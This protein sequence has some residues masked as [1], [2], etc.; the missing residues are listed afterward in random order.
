MRPLILILLFALL[1]ISQINT[2]VD[3]DLWLHIK[4]GEYIVKNLSIPKIDIFSYTLENQALIHYDW[5]SGV[6]YY[7]IFICFGWACINILKASVIALCFFILFLIA[8]KE[9]KIIYFIFFAV[10][11]ILA[12]DYRS[13][14]RPEI[15]SYLLLCVFLYILEKDRHVYLLPLLQV[16]WVNLHGYFILGPVLIV[17]YF[18]NEIFYGNIIKSKRLFIVLGLTIASCLVT[19]YFYHGILYPGQVIKEAF[20]GHK[21]YMQSVHELKSPVNFE[22]TRYIFFWLLVILSSVTFL[23]NLKK[24]KIKHVFV[25]SL[26]FLVSYTAIRYMPLFIFAALPLASI[27]LEEAELTKGIKEKRYYGIAVLLICAAMY[28]FLS[29]RYYVFINQS[30]FKKTEFCF[31]RLLIPSG[32]CDFLEKNKIKGRIFNTMDFGP[33]I[34]YRFYPDRRIFI[35]TRIGFLYKKDFYELYTQAQNYPGKWEAIQK[36]YNFEIAV[37]RHLFTGSERIL[38]YLYNSKDWKLVYY[39]ENSAVFLH[40][41]DENKKAIDN[42]EIDFNKKKLSRGDINIHAARFF[43]NI[44]RTGLAG[45]IYIK[46]LENNSGLLGAGIGLSEIYI[47]EKRYDDAIRLL[48]KQLKCYPKSAELYAN[49][50]KAYWNAGKKIRGLGMLNKALDTDPYSRQ[51]IYAMGIL[52]MEIGETENALKQFEQYL[53]LNPYDPDVCRILAN[54][55]RQKGL[56]K[57]A[58]LEYNEADALE[59][60]KESRN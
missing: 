42:F 34:A 2:I 18:L 48:E 30:D 12:F 38:R 51:A 6:L 39:D 13:V 50:G 32:A 1:V 33:Y 11:S 22:F 47:S 27:N 60:T 41:V 40:N 36:R 23:I 16:L 9:K 7:L 8:S 19:P 31:S 56:F 21:L 52:Y 46:L 58:G 4:S 20:A 3:N 17:I 43:Q 59:G 45:E 49:L 5:I 29:N 15:F 26:F 28:L 57:E 25:F 54:I 53:A 10:L 35:D 37:I 14:A 44:E 55:Y 24:A